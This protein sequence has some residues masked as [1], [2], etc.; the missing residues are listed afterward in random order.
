MATKPVIKQNITAYNKQKRSKP[1][2]KYGYVV[3]H[4]VGAASSAKNNAAYFA[5]GYR[6]ASAHFFVDDDEIWQSVKT[7]YWASWHCGGPLQGP[8]GHKYYGLCKND[9]SIGIEL[10]CKKDASGNLYISDKTIKR[11]GKL[12]KWLM[13]YYNI[14]EARVI[15]HFD[16]TGKDCPHGYTTV[17]TWNKMKEKLVK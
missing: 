5:G 9:N 12:V 4:W 16:V 3:I 2:D 10:C 1:M 14:P 13:D 7:K 6:G 15:R 17:A 11:A 8:K